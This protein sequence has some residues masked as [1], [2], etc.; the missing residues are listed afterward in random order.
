MDTRRWPE[1]EKLAIVE[2]SKTAPVA[3]VAKKH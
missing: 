2:E 3:R 1:E